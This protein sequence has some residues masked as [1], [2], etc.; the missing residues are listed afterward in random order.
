MNSHTEK[1]SLH[2]SHSHGHSH[3]HS[4]VAHLSSRNLFFAVILNIT[5]TVLQLIGGILSGSMALI[6][7]ATHNFSDV[8]SLIIS[9]LANRLARRNATIRQ[10]FGYKRSEI[11]AAFIN[12]ASL[13]IVAIIILIEGIKRLFVQTEIIS[14]WVIILSAIGI[15]V[16]G[17]SAMFIKKDSK[18]NINIKSAYIHLFSDMLTSVAVLI[19]GILI[20]FFNINGIDAILSIIIAFYLIYMSVE[21]FLRSLKILMQFSPT[22]IDLKEIKEHVEEIDGIKNI[23]NIHIWQI[24]EHE[25]MFD[26]HIDLI[27]D[28]NISQFEKILE[29]IKT[30]LLEFGIENFTIQPEFL[31]QDSKNIIN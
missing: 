6:A 17:L 31:I 7:D 30:E 26:A 13:I 5:I 24:N 21:I 8:I 2:H 22:N 11:L 19:G 29:Q 3:G 16:N 15:I 9:Y 28:I 10:T 18:D 25:I 4:H 20:K 14:D 1:K 23:H 27:T 12:S